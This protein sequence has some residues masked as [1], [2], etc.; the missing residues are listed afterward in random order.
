MTPLPILSGITSV[1]VVALGFTSMARALAVAI[2]HRRLGLAAHTSAYSHAW[3]ILLPHVA[4][5]VIA[6]GTVLSLRSAFSFV[7]AVSMTTP[8][9]VILSLL[10]YPRAL[11]RPRR[12]PPRRALAA[13][14]YLGTAASLLMELV[15]PA[16]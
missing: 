8:P 2:R 6:A 7:G 11:R 4:V 3:E 16:F 15:E 12:P 9:L 14:L 10:V 1:A 13:F 5:A